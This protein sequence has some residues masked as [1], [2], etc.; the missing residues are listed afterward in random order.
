MFRSSNTF[1]VGALQFENASRLRFPTFHYLDQETERAHRHSL[2]T[3]ATAE[4]VKKKGRPKKIVADAIDI[5]AQPV[6]NKV[7]KSRV[8]RKSTLTSPTD[9]PEHKN[10]TLVKVQAPEKQKTGPL[11]PGTVQR[12]KSPST[13]SVATETGSQQSDSPLTPLEP[14]PIL[15]QAT[16]FVEFKKQNSLSDPSNSVK[17]DPQSYQKEFKPAGTLPAFS[18]PEAPR[19]ATQDTLSQPKRSLFLTEFF[20][21]P[22]LAEQPA[23]SRSKKPT[24]VS[25]LSND[26]PKVRAAAEIPASPRHPDTSA[27]LSGSSF[28]VTPPTALPTSRQS[29]IR[30]HPASTADL[31]TTALPQSSGQ[32][33]QQAVQPTPPKTSSSEPTSQNA[34]P[35]EPL[36]EGSKSTPTPVMNPSSQSPRRVNPPAKMPPRVASASGPKPLK[37]TEMP[38]EVL[39]HDPK[40]RALSRRWTSLIVAI[41]LLVATSYALY[42]RYTETTVQRRRV[43]LDRGTSTINGGV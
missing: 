20:T 13:K 28:P 9:Q 15:D 12:P 10:A 31:H 21:E 41:P 39:K 42:G 6:V 40:F 26:L 33:V 36:T 25:A 17:I 38:Y 2:R 14:S 22:T 35:S 19:T 18:V 16:A 37:P 34:M 5:V 24:T 7:K 23:W 8:S 29:Q 30:Q 27:R 11:S 4:V 1:I 43:M 32:P 3:M